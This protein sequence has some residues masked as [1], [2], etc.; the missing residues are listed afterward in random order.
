MVSNETTEPMNNNQMRYVNILDYLVVLAR[1]KKFIIWFVTIA[2]I[3]S[4]T[5]LYFVLPRWYKST[6][7]VM[8][9]KQKNLVGLLNTV[10]R[11][12]S[13]L[14]SLGL[15]GGSD[16]LSQFQTILKSRRCLEAVVNRFDLIKVYETKNILE[17]IKE[18]EDNFTIA[19]GKEDVSLEI[20]VYDTDAQRAADM[21]NYFVETLNLIYLELSLTE[22]KSNREFL[23]QRYQQNLRDMKNAE[24]SLK[25]F[26]RKYGIYSLPEALSGKLLSSF[27][28]FEKV[29]EVT[30]RY[31]Q[32]YRDLEIQNKI[33]EFALPMYEQVKLEEQRNTPTVLV[34]DRATPADKP[35]KPRKLLI[36][37][38]V[39]ASSFIIASILAF[40]LEFIRRAKDPENIEDKEKIR[41]IQQELSFRK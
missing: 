28:P 17:A 1:H 22:A 29:P 20:T 25:V 7:S 34:L 15:G 3:V 10:T 31:L 16:D 39:A 41:F 35:S 30:M 26:Q 18:L 8:P 24:D 32:L 11:A 6:S 12:S 2:V 9:P 5:L 33:L 36:T 37:G 13:S 27:V 21:A 40:F 4:A 14:R 38:I 19:M 23:E